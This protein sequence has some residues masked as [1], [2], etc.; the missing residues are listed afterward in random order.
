MD[1]EHPPPVIHTVDDYD[2]PGCR[3]RKEMDQASLLFLRLFH[4]VCVLHHCMP[5]ILVNT[6]AGTWETMDLV[7]K[8][9]RQPI[10]IRP[11]IKDALAQIDDLK[12][13][14]EDLQNHQQ[15]SRLHCQTFTAPGGY[16][17]LP[18][19]QKGP[20]QDAKYAKQ[21][22]PSKPGKNHG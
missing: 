11:D 22:A 1:I 20:S 2:R 17:S 5:A 15:S 18:E 9:S 8:R 16:N 14:V 13:E 21:P 3:A 19:S 10:C 12:M 6:G 7:L 4:G